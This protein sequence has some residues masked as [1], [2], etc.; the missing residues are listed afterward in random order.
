MAGRAGAFA[1]RLTRSAPPRPL[2]P[3]GRPVTLADLAHAAYFAALAALAVYGAHRLWLVVCYRSSTD[4]GAQ[5]EP[6]ELPVVS[7]QLP[8][9]NERTVARRL[10]RAVGALD[11]PRERLEIQVLDD[12]TDETR[13]LVD[14]EVARLLKAGVHARVLRREQRTGFKAGALDRGLRRASGELIC[15]FDADFLPRPDFLRSTVGAFADPAIGMV[16][17]RWGHVNRD[18]SALTR[19]QSTLL[20]GHFV[21]EHEVRHDRGLFFNFN[22]TAGVWRRAA[23]EDAGGWQHDTLTEDLDLS[24]RAQL[25][26]WRFGYRS[27]VVVPAEVPPDIA[28]FHTQQKRWAKGSAQTLRKLGRSIARADVPLR[29]KLE[30]FVHLSANAGY[31]LVLVLALLLPFALRTRDRM[32]WGWNLALF[33][34]CTG[35]VLLFYERSQRAVGRTRLAR[36]LDVPAA[37]ALGI[38]I[39]VAQTRAVLSGLFGST[40]VFERTPKR[41]GGEGG[42][43]RARACGLPWAEFALAAWLGGAVV[44]AVRTRLWTSLP[45]VALFFAGFLWVGAESL[46]CWVRRPGYPAKP[47]AAGELQSVS[48]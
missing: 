10:I 35:S 39:S 28:A 43:Y 45:F 25:A 29:T 15:V 1:E 14:E 40:G 34:L 9:Y 20:D 27:G 46:R 38:G 33:V 5:A 6:G 30:A 19:A 11:Y 21:I 36:V 3:P 12:S 24:Y 17:A 7:V 23:I 32:G 42:A 37:M 47:G 26:G 16:Q 48:R 4:A 13:A 31:P 44:H 2:G 8:L 18:E 22:G 41:G